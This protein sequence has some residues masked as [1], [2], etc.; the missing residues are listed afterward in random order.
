MNDRLHDLLAEMHRLEGELLT[1]LETK[2]KEFLYEV[3]ARRVQF[4]ARILREHRKLA[5]G[6]LRYLRETPL[7]H[8]LIAPVI[9]AALPPSLLFDLTITLYQWICF[10]ACRIPRVRRGDHIV[11]D[12][13]FL[14]YLNAV[15]KL[16]CLYC[17]YFNGLVSYAMEIGARTEQ[18]WCPIRHAQ[19]VRGMH[20]RYRQ[21]FDYGD[22]KAYRQTFE[23]RRRA[24]DDVQPAAEERPPH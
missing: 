23:T 20:S 5:T 13:R 2:K 12:R 11:M 16:N 14:S 8:L 18:Y 9:W 7:R 3:K 19:R 1:E 17:G 15:E 4:D 22:G 24:F 10:P 21:F 6:L